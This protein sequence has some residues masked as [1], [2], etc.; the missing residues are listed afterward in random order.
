[1]G[2]PGGLLSM[3]SH[4]VGHDWSDLAAAGH[5]LVVWW[6]GFYGSAAGSM[7]SIPLG[8]TR[9]RIPHSIAT[10][11]KKKRERERKAKCASNTPWLK[12]QQQQQKTWACYSPLWASVFLSVQWA[13]LRNGVRCVGG[14]SF[15]QNSLK[16]LPDLLP[17]ISLL[18][19][20]PQPKQ[21]FVVTMGPMQHTEDV[22]SHWA[23]ENG[24]CT[25]T[26]N[27]RYKPE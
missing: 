21:A 14:D 20:L 13:G 19:L 5:T 25:L 3:G 26:P 7:G 1:M 27:S 9:S 4:R 2:E 10:G 23:G 16:N 8:A 6:L 17:T 11:K 18:I 22:N 15:I 12:K 24:G